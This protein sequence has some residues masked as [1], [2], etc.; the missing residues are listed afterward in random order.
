M[1]YRDLFVLS[2]LLLLLVACTLDEMTPFPTSEPTAIVEIPTMTSAKEAVTNA[3]FV[4]TSSPTVLARTPTTTP[5]PKETTFTPTSDTTPIPETPT[6]R[7]TVERVY[8]NGVIID[9]L[10]VMVTE[11]VLPRVFVKVTGN[12]VYSCVT[13]NNIEFSRERHSFIMDFNTQ[14]DPSAL[15]HEALIPFSEQME[16]IVEGLSGGP[17]SI[18]GMSLDGTAVTETFTLPTLDETAVAPPSMP[19]PA[20]CFAEDERNGEFVNL[21]DGYCLQYPI[22][23]E[24]TVHNVFV[25]GAAT[26]WGGRLAFQYEPVRAGIS[27]F[28]RDRTN[29]RSLDEIVAEVLAH[30]PR[31]ILIGMDTFAGEP[32]QI[33]EGITDSRRYYLVHSHFWYEIVLMPLTPPP[34]FEEIMVAQRDRLWQTVSESFTW[35]S[36]NLTTQFSFCPLGSQETAPYVNPQAGYCLLYPI[37]FSQQDKAM[38]D[39]TIFGGPI[40]DPVNPAPSQVILQ[41]R[42]EAAN[43]RSLSQIIDAAIALAGDVEIEQSEDVLAGETAVVLT[44]LSGNPLSRDLYTIHHGT[45]YHLRLDP[46]DFRFLIPDMTIVWNTVLDSFTFFPQ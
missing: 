13:L 4:P 21:Q 1:F 17:Y 34:S 39:V 30:N 16:L 41:V 25:S 45:I 37:H 3:T 44:G 27:I 43:G 22:S 19:L 14:R 36:S 38:P 42:T 12:L 29:G 2:L 23:D 7:P 20:N 6:L 15:C 24:A 35:L 32:T 18:T 40:A 46:T 31:A 5:S 33:I 28:K 11:A 9:S 26:I 10:E 8:G